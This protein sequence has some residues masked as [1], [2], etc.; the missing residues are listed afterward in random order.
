M[1]SSSKGE[2]STLFQNCAMVSV[3]LMA[4]GII[5]QEFGAVYKKFFGMF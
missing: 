5:F 4:C 1:S 2:N 3:F